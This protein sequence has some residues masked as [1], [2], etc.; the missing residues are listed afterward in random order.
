M[1]SKSC[2]GLYQSFYVDQWE[3]KGKNGFGRRFQT[4][5]LW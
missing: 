2:L 1:L 5:I 4:Y 3:A